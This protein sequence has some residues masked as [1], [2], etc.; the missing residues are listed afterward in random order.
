MSVLFWKEARVIGKGDNICRK[1]RTLYTSNV[2][3]SRWR[4]SLE[5][6]VS[7]MRPSL[8]GEVMANNPFVQVLDST[9]GLFAGAMHLY[10]EHSVNG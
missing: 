2:Q 8:R 3:T 1:E 9:I 4:S 6:W 7:C 5:R 10:A